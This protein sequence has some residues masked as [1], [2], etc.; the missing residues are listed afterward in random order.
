MFCMFVFDVLDFPKI[1]SQTAKRWERHVEGHKLKVEGDAF[2]DKLNTDEFF[3][4]N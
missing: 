2:A 3:E 4:P 1:C